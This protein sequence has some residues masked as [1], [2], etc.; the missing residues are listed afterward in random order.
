MAHKDSKLIKF[1]R[2]VGETIIN[3][4]NIPNKLP[5]LSIGPRARKGKIPSSLKGFFR[6]RHAGW[7]EYVMLKAQ[8]GVLVLFVI[9]VLYVIL[10]SASPFIFLPLIAAIIGY[11]IYLSA[12]QL[13]SAFGRD[14]PAYRS[15]VALCVSIALV[16]ILVTKYVHF[17]AFESLYTPFLSVGLVLGMV[18]VGFA[19]FKLKYGRDYTYGEVQEIKGEKAMVKIGYDIRSN[20]KHGIYLLESPS[21]LKPGDEVKIAVDRSIFGLKGSRPATILERID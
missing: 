17:R 2:K 21:G 15:F 19:G 1:F 13:K 12:I 9:T 20:V 8:I 16:L 6:R 3:W 11:L 5:G 4:R 18:L 14:Y 7:P 10:P